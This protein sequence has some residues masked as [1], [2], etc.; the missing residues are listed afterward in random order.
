MNIWLSKGPILEDN[1]NKMRKKNLPIWHPAFCF[2]QT[3]TIWIAGVEEEKET[4]SYQTVRNVAY[5]NFTSFPEIH[6]STLTEIHLSTLTVLTCDLTSGESPRSPLVAEQL[7][8]QQKEHVS[9]HE[10]QVH[11]NKVFRKSAKYYALQWR[12]IRYELEEV[13]PFDIRFCG[14]TH[15]QKYQHGGT[16]SKLCSEEILTR[17]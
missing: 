5:L 6:L 2:N 4:K 8:F 9:Y 14:K 15:K 7:Y 3:K 11:W 16:D 13:L 17:Y 10:Y 1:K 12:K